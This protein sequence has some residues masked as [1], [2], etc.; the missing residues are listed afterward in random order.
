MKPTEE[1]PIEVKEVTTEATPEITEE[2]PIETKPHEP[3]ASSTDIANIPSEQQQQE[4]HRQEE[5]LQK[6][7]ESETPKTT[8]EIKGISYSHQEIRL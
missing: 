1:V 5:I 6:S 7:V 2:K 3:S 4:L 8:D